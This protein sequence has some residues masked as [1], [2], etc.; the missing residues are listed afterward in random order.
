M[1]LRYPDSEFP[2]ASSLLLQILESLCVGCGR[3]RPFSANPTYFLVGNFFLPPNSAKIR[4]SSEHASK[5]HH[6]FLP[7][8]KDHDNDAPSK[9]AS[10][11]AQLQNMWILPLVGYIGLGLGFGFLTLAIGTIH[12]LVQLPE[13]AHANLTNSFGTLLPLRTRRGAYGLCQKASYA[14]DLLGYWHTNRPLH[15]R[16][17]PFLAIS[18]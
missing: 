8:L 18:P 11:I 5:F 14:I 3:K 10:L 9:H 16:W 12:S 15:Y 17:L 7:L 4:G 2:G 1:Q 13:R 6:P